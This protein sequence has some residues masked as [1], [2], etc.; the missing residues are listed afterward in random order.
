MKGDAVGVVV[1]ESLGLALVTSPFSVPVPDTVVPLRR[2]MEMPSAIYPAYAV[3]LS[4]S[5]ATLKTFYGVPTR[6]P[7][8]RGTKDSNKNVRK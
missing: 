4:L 5:F 2:V 1:V 8:S 7:R 6:I 3:G